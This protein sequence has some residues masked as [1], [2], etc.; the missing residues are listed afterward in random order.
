[1]KNGMPWYDTDGNVIHAHGGWMLRVGEYWYWYGED[2]TDENFVNCYRT[3]DFRNFEFRGH[4]LTA[5]SPAKPSYVAN[6]DLNLKKKP[7]VD[8]A[9]AAL[10]RFDSEGRL[11][12]NIERPKVLYDE[13]TGKYV[14]WMHYENG[15]NYLDAA[16]AV[17]S[18]D[19]P[20]G[21]FVYHGSFNPFGQ[22]ARDCTIVRQDE[23]WYFAAAG[24]DNKDLFIYRMTEDCLSVDKVA[25]V[26]FQNQSREAPAFFQKEGRWF[27]LS[28][29][30]TGWKPNQGA[31]AYAKEGN[32]EGRWSLLSNFGDETTFRSQPAFV[33]PYEKDGVMHYY[34]FADRWGLSGEEYFTSSYVVLEIQFDEEGLPFIEY[35]EEAQLPEVE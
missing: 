17:A 24:R 30:C 15:L 14:M 9:P 10:R 32:L 34:Y 7:E 35:S 13:K 33:L 5:N 21:E 31:F 28:S 2:R 12:A 8:L 23:D 4:V 3:R 18:C 27:I 26:L 25:N 6:A 11:L 20:D 1:M 29:F 16:C 22:M 19:T